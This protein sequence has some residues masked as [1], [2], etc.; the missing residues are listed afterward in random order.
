MSA[1][2]ELAAFLFVAA[3]AQLGFPGSCIRFD[4]RQEDQKQV[5]NRTSKKRR[6]R[7]QEMALHLRKENVMGQSYGTGASLRNT[8]SSCTISWPPFLLP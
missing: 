4:A 5:E 6:T 7:S 1:L 2:L 8:W 3:F